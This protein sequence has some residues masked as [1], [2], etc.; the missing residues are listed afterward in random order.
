MTI[1]NGAYAMSCAMIFLAASQMAEAGEF[2]LRGY[3]EP[4]IRLF[5]DSP[6]NAGQR[7]ST[8]S[9]AGEVRARYFWDNDNQSIIVTPFARLDQHDR[10]RSHWDLR[11]ARYAWRQGRWELIAGIDKVFWGVTEAVHLVDVINQLDFVEDPIKQEIK[12]GQPMLRVRTMQEFGTLEA[13]ILPGFRERN[14]PGA[15]GRP[16]TDIAIDRSLTAYES[17]EGKRHVDI[18]ARY[19]NNFGMFDIGLAYFQGTSRDPILNVALDAG[20]AVVLA[21]FYPQMKQGSVDIQATLGAWLYKLEGFT[22]HELGDTYSA[23]TGGIEYTFHDV[24]ESGGDLGIVL[25][26]AHDTRG[27][28]QRNPYQ[29]D[30]FVALRWAANDIATSSMLGG[31][32]IDTQTGALGFRLRGER[33]IAEDYRLSIEAYAFGNVPARDPV[34]HV[35]DDDYIQ[36]RVAR[37]F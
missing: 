13:F 4:E 37:F 1:R 26:Y 5:D 19:S 8:L 17:G 24:A 10:R 18:A 34:F 30:V 11:E 36:I 33:R 32:A 35:A 25:E 15:E 21:P 28:N 29:D 3:V 7:N 16:A 27:M 22:R 12:L 23:V 9:I 31:V 6:S 2:D 14:Y 20:G